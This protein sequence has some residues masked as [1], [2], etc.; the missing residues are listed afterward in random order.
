MHVSRRQFFRNAAAI[1]LGFTGLQAFSGCSRGNNPHIVNPELIEDPL[2]LLE[3][4]P[5]FTYRV[6]SRAGREMADG[7]LVPARPDGMATFAGDN[8]LT[9]LL[10]NH[11]IDVNP[12]TG[13]YGQNNER[14]ANI[15]RTKL[16]DAGFGKTPSLGGTTT[17]VYDTKK[18]E[19]VREFLSL[20][21]TQRNCAGGPTPWNT[22]IS[23]EETVMRA[24][25]ACEKDHGYNFEVPVTTQ[26][27]LATPVPLRAMGRFNHEAVAVDPRTGIIY[28]TEDRHDGLIY[29]FLPDVP[30]Q[31]AR[32]GRLQALAVIDRPSFDTRNWV[33]EDETPA[34][35]QGA[36]LAVR[37]IDLEGIDAPDD[38]LRYRGF[39]QGAARFARGEGMWYGRGEIFFACTSGGS[40]KKGQ[41]WK[42]IP[43]D[44]EGHPG[45]VDQPGRLE[46]FI[47]PNDVD[48]LENADNIIVAPWGDLFICEDGGGEQHVLRVT[49]AGQVSRF[50]TNRFSDSELAGSCF[51]PDGSTL[52]VNIQAEGLTLAITGPWERYG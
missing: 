45:E 52:F 47:E 48:V 43:A 1:S 38:D 25:N 2:Q 44:G 23:C 51:A 32:G 33:G 35:S 49:P 31:L 39:E 12:K 34:V 8:G 17:V 16:Y 11:E 13:P 46:L 27:G 22:W 30:G 20:A 5:G 10:R 15:D 37:W 28:Q 18:Q 6:I 50:A 21:G 4:P 29:R 7:F 26:P 14:F 19:V 40:R 41:I 24:C 3:L 36:S 9:V 42:Y